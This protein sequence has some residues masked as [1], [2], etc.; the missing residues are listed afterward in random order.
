[1]VYEK[2]RKTVKEF[3]PYKEWQKTF[4][5]RKAKDHEKV[6]DTKK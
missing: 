4:A 3:F 6:M 5:I 2:P 1:M